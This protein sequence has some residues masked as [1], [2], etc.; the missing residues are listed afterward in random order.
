MAGK[1]VKQ[2]ELGG[3]RVVL[4]RKRGNIGKYVG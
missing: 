3:E 2:Q 4:F 1:E